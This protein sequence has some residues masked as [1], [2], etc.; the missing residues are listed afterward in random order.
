MNVKKICSSLNLL[1]QCQKYHL[2][3]WQCPHLLFLVMGVVIIAVIVTSYILGVYFVIDPG[4]VALIILFT[5]TVLLVIAYIVVRSFERLAE[6]SRLKSEFISIVSHQ[7]RSPLSNL[8]WIIE[9]LMSGEVGRVGKEQ[10]DYFQILKKNSARMN[11]LV[12]DLLTVSRIET[13]SLPFKKRDISLEEVVEKM[14]SGVKPF[15]RA[16]NIKIEVESSKN[17]PKVFAD[18]FWIEQAVENLL[19]NAIHYTEGPGTIKIKLEKRGKWLRFEIQDNG[20]GIPEEDQKYIFTKFFRAENV[21]RYQ[22]EGAGLG[23]YIVKSIIERSNG[24]VSFKSEEGRGSTFWF[25]LPIR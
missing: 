23:L 24:K 7:L 19:D 25:D 5:A 10:V 1:K 17:L 20:V 22:T 3:L 2:P 11:E 6:A 21:L 9:L 13:N 15:A 18:P 12:S 4:L 14:V 8:N 16:S